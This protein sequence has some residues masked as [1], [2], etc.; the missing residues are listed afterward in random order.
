MS[1][2]DRPAAC[3]SRAAARSASAD[4]CR[5]SS[6]AS[7]HRRASTIRRATIRS[8]SWVSINAASPRARRR[9]R[10]CARGGCSRPRWSALEGQG[11]GLAADL[12]V[13]DP[14]IDAGLAGEPVG[15]AHGPPTGPDS[16]PVARALAPRDAIPTTLAR[17]AAAAAQLRSPW[18]PMDTPGPRPRRRRCRRSSDRSGPNRVA[19]RSAPAPRPRW[20][21]T[22]V[23]SLTT[24]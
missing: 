21:C 7:T 19:S 18:R 6:P 10:R 1:A 24:G 2:T 9:R 20:P 11:P 4:W 23:L 16:V 8:R 15:A 5:G 3:A 14:P 17:P 12:H 22:R 13:L